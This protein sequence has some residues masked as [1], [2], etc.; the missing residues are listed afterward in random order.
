MTGVV[1]L[2]LMVFLMAALVPVWPHSATWGY[3]PSGALGLVIV[4]FAVLLFTGEL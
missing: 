4:V 3:A 1:L 2:T